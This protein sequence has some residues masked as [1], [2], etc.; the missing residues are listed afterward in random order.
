MMILHRDFTDLQERCEQL[1]EELAAAKLLN[2]ELV[3]AIQAAHTAALENLST[4][5]GDLAL[6]LETRTVQ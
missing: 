1:E 5:L 4:F 3:Q 2:R 6:M